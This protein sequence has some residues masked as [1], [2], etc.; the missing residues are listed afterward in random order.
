MKLSKQERIAALVIL[1]IVILAVGAFMLVKPKFEEASRTKQTLSQRQ[2]ELDKAKARQQLKGSLRTEIEQE[3]E[4]GEHLADMFFPE[5]SSY[6]ADNA[7]REFIKQIDFPVVAEELTVDEPTT[8]TLS[9]SF[10]TPTE[11]SYA[12]KTYVTQGI[13]PTEE[14]NIVAQRNQALQQAL[15]SS[16]TI[17]ASRIQFKAAVLTREDWLKF[18]D[19]INEYE[20]ETEDENAPKIRKAICIDAAEFAYDDVNQWYDLMID[21]STN[22]IAREGRAILREM[23]LRVDDENPN[24]QDPLADPDISYYYIHNIE[25]SIVFYSIERMQDPTA[26]LDAQDGKAA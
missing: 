24:E 23:G 6:E 25:G 1:A 13:E 14:E 10:F 22:A 5:L 12:L 8:D 4:E 19:A 2:D 7:F 3:Y 15:A 11:V 16:Q 9:V 20:V 17:G 21:V 18:L 26:Q